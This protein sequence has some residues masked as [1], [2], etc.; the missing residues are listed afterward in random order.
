MKKY[1][2]TSTAAPPPEELEL[3]IITKSQGV[4]SQ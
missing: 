1:S 4:C 2:N 3:T